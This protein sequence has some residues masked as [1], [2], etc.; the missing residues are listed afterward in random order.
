MHARPLYDRLLSRGGGGGVRLCP[1]CNDLYPLPLRVGDDVT[2][3]HLDGRL[4]PRI[5]GHCGRAGGAR[6]GLNL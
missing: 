5:V 1:M 6:H 2:I 3:P 4:H